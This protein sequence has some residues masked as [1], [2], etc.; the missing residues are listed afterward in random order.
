MRVSTSINVF[1]TYT[2][3]ITLG[4]DILTLAGRGSGPQSSQFIFE[5]APAPVT[6]DNTVQ[7][8]T[9]GDDS[10]SISSDHNVI[11]G[12]EGNDTFTGSTDFS[13]LDGGT[14]SDSFNFDLS[15]NNALLGGDDGAGD[16]LYITGGS[17]NDLMGAGGNDWV[18]VGQ[19][20]A[21]GFDQQRARR[22]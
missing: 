15:N 22:R 9:G 11:Y 6:V 16:S 5:M 4:A 7:R 10:I 14:G 18:G 17:N 12:A 19:S 13:T 21:T 1:I 3:A 8:F 2:A 20:G